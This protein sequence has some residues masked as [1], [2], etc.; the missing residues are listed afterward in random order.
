MTG[1]KAMRRQEIIQRT[2]AFVK[3]RNEFL[4]KSSKEETDSSRAMNLKSF[5]AQIATRIDC[6][7][8]KS[9]AEILEEIAA[10]C[11]EALKL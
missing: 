4:A 7:S 2:E 5:I 8:G 11:R 1:S 3:E 6:N 10:L 9:K